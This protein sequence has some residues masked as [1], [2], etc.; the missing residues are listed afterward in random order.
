[1]AQAPPD[2]RPVAAVDNG[3]HFRDPDGNVLEARYYGG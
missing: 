1:M 3:R 2:D